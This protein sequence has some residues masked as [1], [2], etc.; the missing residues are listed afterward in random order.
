MKY[1]FIVQGEGRG[2]LTQA[3]TLEN[4]LLKHGHSVVGVLVGRNSNRKLPDFFMQRIKAPVKCFDTITFVPSANN[5]QPNIIKTFFYNLFIGLKFLPS[6]RKIKNEINN[7]GADAVI[8]FYEALGTLGYISSGKKIPMFTIAHQFLFLHRE[9]KLPESGYEGHYAL[10]VFSKFIARTSYKVLALSFRKMENDDQ[11]NLVVVPPLLRDEVRAVIPT[12]GD[13]I[14]GYLVNSGFAE[15]VLLWH[16]KHPDI[17]L[18]FFWDNRSKGDVYKVDNTLTFY[19][20]NDK[21]FLKQMAGCRC[22]ASTAGFESICEAMY[23]GKPLMMVP[24]HIEQKCNAFD[25]MQ[26]GA[27]ISSD[28]FDLTVLEN[29]VRNGYKKDADF[30]SWADSAETLILK[31]LENI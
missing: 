28:K 24:V 1:L 5:K 2:H 30:A 21:E 20:L 22:Y 8:N 25:A 18:N 14:L 6:I 26:T 16:S 7:T 23:M 13:Y 4:M 31:E 29:F 3:I 10:N 9:M 15:E 17:K 12:Q 19:Y 27:A 11:N